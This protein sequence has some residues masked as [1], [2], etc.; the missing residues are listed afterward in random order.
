[1]MNRRNT[2]LENGCCK[3]SKEATVLWGG[4]SCKSE[5]VS[6]CIVKTR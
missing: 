5:Q 6:N 2:L 3:L 4:S 1:M